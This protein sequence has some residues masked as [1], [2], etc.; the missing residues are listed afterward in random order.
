MVQKSHRLPLTNDR[1]LVCDLV[2][3]AQ[4]TPFAPISRTIDVSALQ[5]L[6]KKI[7]PRLPWQVILM[8]AYGMV[9]Q[10][11]PVLR[12]I[13]VPLPYPHIYQH[14]E[15]VCLLTVGREYQGVNRLF[16][17]RFN[18]PENH[19]LASLLEQLEIYRRRPV[20]EIQQLRHQVRFAKFPWWIRQMGWKLMTHWMPKGRAK[21]MG[22]FGMSLSGFRDTK[23]LYHLGPCTTILGYDQFCPR[24]NAH[25]TL[26]FDHRILDGKPAVDVMEALRVTLHG[27]ILDE[28]QRMAADP[29]PSP[30][31]IQA[32]SG[33][34]PFDENANQWRRPA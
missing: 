9:S 13:Y 7:R 24:G 31:A 30:A 16:F 3:I 27:P 18:Q 26:T 15:S 14:H 11:F 25:I 28:L 21:L 32:D 17:A 12:Q 5:A 34:A 10:Q 4:K 8:R 2:A 1:R 23:G 29:S 6:R 19:S 33:Y 22:T 20:E